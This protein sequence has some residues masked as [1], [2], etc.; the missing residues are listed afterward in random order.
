MNDHSKQ[1][2]IIPSDEHRSCTDSPRKMTV[3]NKDFV[4]VMQCLLR[5][6]DNDCVFVFVCFL[7]LS[8]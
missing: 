4:T 8:F 2:I 1:S 6:P 7:V 5:V 3:P